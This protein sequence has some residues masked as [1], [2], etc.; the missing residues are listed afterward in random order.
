MGYAR[1]SAVE[2]APGGR[3]GLLSD[4]GVS[5]QR[6]RITRLSNSDTPKS[7]HHE[8]R[9]GLIKGEGIGYPPLILREPPAKGGSSTA[10]A[11]Q[12]P[13][14]R[15][16]QRSRRGMTVMQRSRLG[17]S[18][19]RRGR[20]DLPLGHSTGLRMSVP[21]PRDGFTPRRTYSRLSRAGMTEG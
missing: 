7:Q 16:M 5:V 6:H 13:P 4:T 15:V 8:L 17:E 18:A 21:T 3:S 1:A 11:A 19:T 2:T 10:R 14:A 12:A 9:K 20:E